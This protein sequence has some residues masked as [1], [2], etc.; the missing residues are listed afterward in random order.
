MLY[1]LTYMWNLF[2]KITIQKRR[3][4]WWL[5]EVVGLEGGLGDGGLRYKLSVVR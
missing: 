2:K 5:P 1:D 4:D 3:S